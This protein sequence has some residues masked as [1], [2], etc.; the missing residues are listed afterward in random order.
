MIS[1]IFGNLFDAGWYT[2]PLNLIGVAWLAWFVSWMIA[3]VWSRQT[4]AVAGMA[5]LPSRAVTVIGAILLLSGVHRF[6]FGPTW[7]VSEAVQWAM[8]GLVLAGIAFAWWARL[9]LGNLWSGHV[10][11]KQEHRVVEQGPYALVRH[12]IYTGILFGAFATAVARGR[13]DALIGA[14]LVTL[15]FYMKARLEERFIGAELGAEYEAYRKRVRMLVP[16]L[17]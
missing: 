6:R 14:A 13:L 9:T 16:Y 1:W 12:P 11:R 4:V 5:E 8:L 15:G 7:P 2:Q 10:T 17:L 3:A